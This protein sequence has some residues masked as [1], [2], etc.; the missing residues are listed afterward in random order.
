MSPKKIAYWEAGG[1][2]GT[3]NFSIFQAG[4]QMV[5]EFYIKRLMVFC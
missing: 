2:G 5:L 3:N 4:L 1:K